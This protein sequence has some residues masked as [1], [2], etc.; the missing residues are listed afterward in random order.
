MITNIVQIVAMTLFM[1]AAGEGF[2]GQYAVASV[3][4]NRADG[5]KTK[6]VEVCKKPKQF[7]CWNNV[8]DGTMPK[9]KDDPASR[10]AWGFSQRI[11]KAMVD[12]YFM[13]MV[14]A[15]H[16]HVKTMKKYPSWARKLR[17]VA[18]IGNHVFYREM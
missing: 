8:K 15:S 9:I 10:Q 6:F 3:I 7:S 11:T 17:K 4:W 1:E 13:P 14:D 5:D 2:D 12:G 16:Y 18:T